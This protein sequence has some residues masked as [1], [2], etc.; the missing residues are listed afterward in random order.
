MKSRYAFLLPLLAF[1]LLLSVLPLLW[2]LALAVG[3]LDGTV[4]VFTGAENLKAVLT[5]YR[6]HG[7]LGFTL[8]F[9][10]LATALELGLG[11]AIA[12][13]VHESGAKTDRWRGVLAIPFFMAP[14]AIGYLGLTVF[15]EESGPLNLALRAVHLPGIPWLSSGWGATVSLLLADLWE[16]TPFCF[17]ILYAALIAQPA[18]LYDAA[19]LEPLTRWQR[20]RYLTFPLLRPTAALVGLLRFLEALKTTDLPFSLT[21]G[22]PGA[23]TETLSLLAYRKTMKFFDFGYGSALAWVLFILVMIAAQVMARWN[24]RRASE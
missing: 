1:V 24:L 18:D 10:V 21:G 23:A 16:W 7:A 22:G 3:R 8:G 11:M 9:A 20:F 2:S 6:F 15:H 5:D 17:L 13:A 19:R 12:V 4:Y 14:V